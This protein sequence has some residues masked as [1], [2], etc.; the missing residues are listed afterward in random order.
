[1]KKQTK[2]N[3]REF[4]AKAAVGYDIQQKQSTSKSTIERKDFFESQ[5]EKPEFDENCKADDDFVKLYS[6]PDRE[7][8]NDIIDCIKKFDDTETLEK[9]GRYFDVIQRDLRQLK[10]QPDRETLRKE[11]KKF[12]TWM[13]HKQYDGKIPLIDTC[14]DEYLKSKE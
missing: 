3:V 14:I 7:T 6:Q 9:K 5:M 13:C 4:A 11:L 8:L 10:S 12:N 2:K 1:M